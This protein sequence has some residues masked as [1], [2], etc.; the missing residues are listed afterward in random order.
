MESAVFRWLPQKKLAA[1]SINRPTDNGKKP[2]NSCPMRLRSST[3]CGFY[4]VKARRGI[5][6]HTG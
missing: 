3:P 1:K 6:M 2:T 4:Y 5:I